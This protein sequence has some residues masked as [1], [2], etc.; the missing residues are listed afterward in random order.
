MCTHSLPEVSAENMLLAGTMVFDSE[1]CH[2][3]QETVGL[4]GCSSRNA[5]CFFAQFSLQDVLASSRT[6]TREL[7]SQVCQWL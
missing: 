7:K 3:R 2:G 5:L 6:G 4:K 1:L